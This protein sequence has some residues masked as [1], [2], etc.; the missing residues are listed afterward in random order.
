MLEKGIAYRTTGVVNWDPVDQTVLA[1]EQVID[2]RGWRT[3]A[4]VEKREI[5]MY[6]LRITEYAE[7]LL[8]AL[9]GAAGLA[10]A[11]ADDAG[12]LDRPLRGPRDRVPGRGPD[13][14]ARHL[15]HAARHA[16][17]ASPT[18]RSRRSIRSRRRGGAATW[19]CGSSST[20]AAHQAVTEA[21]LETA[22]KARH[23]DRLPRHPPA[24]RA[25]HPDL[26]RELRADGLRH[27]RGHVGAR[28]RPARLGVRARATGCAS[29]R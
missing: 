13:E 8:G 2:G 1:N 15:H 27:R 11:R 21:A 28:A 24:H 9:D 5:P 10:R 14:H 19:T 29:T 12:E 4:L 26:G 23:A 25:A 18:W 3:G 7:E 22:G 16:A 6:Y 20:S 17:T